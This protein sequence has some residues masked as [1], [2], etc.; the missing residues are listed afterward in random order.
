[1]SANSIKL[2]NVAVTSSAAELN[3][4]TGIDTTAAELDHVHGVTSAIQTQLNNRYTKAEADAAFI[5]SS[6][7]SNTVTVGAL[8]SGSITTNFGDIFPG[9]STIRTDGNMVAGNLEVDNVV[10]NN[11]T[12]GHV[13]NTSLLLLGNNSLTINSDTTVSGKVTA[14]NLK[15]G[16]TDVTATASEINKLSGIDTTAAELDRVHGVTSAI[17]PQIDAKLDT[18]TANASYAPINGGAT[19]VTTGALDSGSITSNFGSINVGSSPI[20]TSGDLQGGKMTVDNVVIDSSTIGH[21]SNGNLLLLEATKF[22]VNKDTEIQGKMTASSIRLGATDVTATASE[23]NTLDGITSTTAELNRLD[24]FT[25]TAAKLN[26]T[27]NVT[28][29][30]Q[31]QFNNRYTKA[32]ADAAFGTLSSV[33]DLGSG[34][35]TPGF[36]NIDV[37]SSNITSGGLLSIDTDADQNDATADS[38]SGRLTALVQDK[39][40]TYIMEVLVHTLLTRQVILL[41]RPLEEVQEL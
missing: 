41:C 17:Q 34:S 15:L 5:T 36:G 12:I 25:G 6:G 33:G 21:T 11:S 14:T 27:N 26:F 22:T 7:S 19:I 3:K 29:D 9:S 28:S 30:I 31:A 8:D 1:M 38:A 24:G 23:L 16:A 39:T 35:I 32:E 18:A 20:T 10:I 2:N 37:G 4:L 13:N 40:L